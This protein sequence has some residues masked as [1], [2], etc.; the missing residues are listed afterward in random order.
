MADEALSFQIITLFP[1]LF[2]AFQQSGLMSHAVREK[3]VEISAIQLRE[4]AINTHGQVDDNPYG[5]GSG[6]VMRC[7]SG[8][9]AIRQ[10]RAK[11]PNAKVVLFTP[12]GTPLTQPRIRALLAE[13][14]EFILLCPRY[15]G[16]DERL[17]EAEVDEEVSLGDFILMGGEIPAQA[18]M[19][20]LTRLLPGVLNNE[21]SV[22]NESFE[23]GLLEH[24]QYT[25]PREFEGAEVPEVLVSGNHALIDKWQREHSLKDTIE[26]RPDLFDGPVKPRGEVCVALM[27]YP[28]RGKKGD[29]I[30]SSLTNIDI[31]DIARS[32]RT[33]GISRFYIVHPVRV[34]R[35]LAEKICSHWI[36]GFGSTY[37]PNRREALELISLVPDFDDVLMDIEQRQK[38]L[39]QIVVTSASPLED[40]LSYPAFRAQLMRDERPHL[41]LFGTG[42][43]MA[44]E[45]LNRANVRLEPIIGPT[46]WNHLSVRAAAA[47]TF[48][49]LFGGTG[50]G[51]RN[52]L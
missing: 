52:T 40:K 36:E 43:G 26:R 22:V 45:L 3:L 32:C 35:K 13:S 28:V 10:A 12:R 15:E 48:D 17:I 1:E 34:L 27:H 47:I 2:G 44:D 18:F 5:G 6:M 14:K 16:V 49:R 21:Q 19:E 50:G 33:Y 38:Q 8:A 9:A 4:H 41:I 39:P 11:S 37:N 20:S 7:E 29:I 51:L 31:H 30:T 24:A 25:K 42:W 46:E 23:S